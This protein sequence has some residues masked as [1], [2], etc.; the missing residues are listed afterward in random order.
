MLTSLH[1]LLN[2]PLGQ[3]LVLLVLKRGNNLSDLWIFSSNHLYVKAKKHKIATELTFATK[4][5][6]ICHRFYP[7][8][9]QIYTSIARKLICFSISG[10][11]KLS[12]RNF[13]HI[14]LKYF[15]GTQSLDIVNYLVSLLYTCVILIQ[16]Q[17]DR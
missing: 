14:F 7:N 17:S 12:F 4:Q 13:L 6:Q 3:P 10:C 11:T 9:E 5:R 8:S 16:I 15:S 1:P 2:P